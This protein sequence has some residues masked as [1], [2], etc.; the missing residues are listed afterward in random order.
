VLNR[1]ILSVFLVYSTGLR[2]QEADSGSYE[3]C[4]GSFSAFNECFRRDSVLSLK[5]SKGFFPAT[6]HNLAYQSRFACRMKEKE[7]IFF[8]GGAMLTLVLI[9]NDNALDRKIRPVRSDHKF[10]ESV[11]PH[12]T[13]L[14][15]YYGYLLLTGFGGYSILFHNY[16]AFRVALLA[17]QAAAASGLWTRVGKILTGR[18]RPGETY[19]DPEYRS[20]H[21]FGPFGQFN[22]DY[23]SRR[24]I[25]SFDAF[26]SGHTGAAF[27]VATVFADQY[28]D[29]KAVPVT[30][31][32]L[33]ALVG[34]SRLIEHQHWVSDVFVGAVV[35]YFCG[36]QV[37]ASERKSFPSR[38]V[39]GHKPASF[40]YPFSDGHTNGLAWK[41]VF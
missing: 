4:S 35:G 31:Y 13:E 24:G 18:M 5:S 34:I 39:S 25:G 8:T 37:S 12:F 6:L 9:H 28:R 2:S 22:G 21:W 16:R 23:N 30:A 11:S 10:I 17:T 36:K 14:G 38:G 20:D 26:P 41:I 3:Y 27:A 15:D 1:L 32:S 7:W 19:G 33:A 29:Y 40:F